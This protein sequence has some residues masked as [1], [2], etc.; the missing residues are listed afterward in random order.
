MTFHLVL[1]EDKIGS[2]T[3][4]RKAHYQKLGRMYDSWEQGYREAW[5]VG[6]TMA[7]GSRL[8]LVWIDVCAHWILKSWLVYIS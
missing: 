5:P 8:Q 1:N 7:L 2:P 4:P 3:Q 6:L